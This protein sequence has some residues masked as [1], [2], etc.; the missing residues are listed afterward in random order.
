MEYSEAK[1][2]SNN[3]NTYYSQKILV[4]T[5]NVADNSRMSQQLTQWILSPF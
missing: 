4:K 5:L 2:K 1:L 3:D